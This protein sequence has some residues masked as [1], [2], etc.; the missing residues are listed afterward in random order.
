MKKVSG[1]PRIKELQEQTLQNPKQYRS[2]SVGATRDSLLFHQ[3]IAALI[4]SN[5]PANDL[6]PKQLVSQHGFKAGCR[7][8]TSLR[9]GGGSSS[10]T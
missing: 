5:L 10:L 8:E 3:R 9:E 1:H 4:A 6:T 7:P 2:L